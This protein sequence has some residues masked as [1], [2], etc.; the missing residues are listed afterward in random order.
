MLN[1]TACFILLICFV[2]CGSSGNGNLKFDFE[3]EMLNTAPTGWSSHFWGPGA[4]DWE[5]A[6]DGGNKVFA[7][8]RSDN[9]RAHFNMAVYDSLK[10]ADV[11][12]SVKFRAVKGSIDQ[13]G[14][15]LWRYI[16]ESNHYIV[17][18][19]PLEDN[20]V[21]YKMEYGER[22]DLSLI[23]K[24]KTYGVKVEPMGSDWHTLGLT[25]EG[26]LFTVFL[27]GRQLFQVNDSTFTDAG[28]IGLW[29]KADAVTYF[30]DLQITIPV[31]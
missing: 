11:G 13:G 27:D 24:G 25:A 15:F 26:N 29:T 10:A 21:L 28:K 22:T 12:L 5:V 4:T 14:G 7:Q 3:A 6:D 19:N 9:P 16:D 17:R 2:S 20:V 18:A 8:L 23:G 31:R 1:Q 30:D